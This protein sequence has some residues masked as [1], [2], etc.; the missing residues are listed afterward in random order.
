MP[1]ISH[2]F[3]RPPELRSRVSF[4]F[5]FNIFSQPQLM[6]LSIKRHLIKLI[7]PAKPNTMQRKDYHQSKKFLPVSRAA[8]KEIFGIDNF[9]DFDANVESVTQSWGAPTNELRDFLRAVRDRRFQPVGFRK[10]SSKCS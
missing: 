2:S 7:P 10:R 1:S 8:K 9:V 6:G 4:A 3:N 5:S